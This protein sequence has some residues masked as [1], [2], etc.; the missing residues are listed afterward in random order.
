MKTIYIIETNFAGN[1]CQAMQFA[2][3]QGYRVHFLTSN[4]SDYVG[5]INPLPT[6]IADEYTVIDCYNFDALANLLD[7][8]K[9][10]IAAI[11]TFDDFHLEVCAKLSE[12][13]SLNT[14]SSDAIA[15]VRDKQVARELINSKHTSVTAFSFSL[16]NA[17]KKA[18]LDYPFVVKPADESGSVG[19]TVCYNES[20]WQF[21]INKLIDLPENVRSYERSNKILVE[22]Y[23]GGE[24][25]SAELIWCTGTSDWQLIGVTKKHVTIGRSRVELGHTFPCTEDILCKKQVGSVIKSWLCDIGLTHCVAHVEFKVYRDQLYLIEVNARAAGGNIAQLV[26]LCLDI[27]LVE[28]SLNIALGS[29]DHIELPGSSRFGAIQFIVPE[30]KGSVIDIIMPEAESAIC[31]INVRN[32]F[33]I[34]LRGEVSASSRLGYCIS[35]ADTFESAEECAISFVGGCEVRYA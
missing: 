17:P 26:Q 14:P 12:R 31:K 19:V 25:Y 22:E 8:D 29:Q 2:R 21:A 27:D 9:D 20:D 4:P 5:R 10:N 16:Q 24:E 3:Q 33:P 35:L 13:Y 32:A 23:I 11:V 34:Q 18:P 1:G 28:C 30:Q 7:Q 6:D 15:K